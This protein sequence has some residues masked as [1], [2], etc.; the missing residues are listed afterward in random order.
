MKRARAVAALIIAVC[1]ATATAANARAFTPS[2]SVGIR[3]ID[4]VTISPDGKHVAYLLR[5]ADME[6]NRYVTD[7]MVIDVG[8][9]T[10]RSVVHDASGLAD[11]RWKPDST[12]IAYLAG[13]KQGGGESEQIDLL[14]L[15]GERRTLS[16]VPNGVDE[17]AWRPDGAAI[18]LLT[19]E[20]GSS[21]GLGFAVDDGGFPNAQ[22][23]PPERLYVL[24]VASGDAAPL[25]R[26]IKVAPSS[27]SWSGDGR[28]LAFT[29]LESTYGRESYRS[30]AM[31]IDV[32]TRTVRPLSPHRTAE[33]LVGFAP[34]TDAIAYLYQ[35]NGD[36]ASSQ[37][38]YVA[39]PTRPSA[40]SAESPDLNVI[41]ASW[42]SDGALLFAAN[43]GLTQ[44]LFVVGA[45]G[46]PR[47]LS[48][49]AFEPNIAGGFSPSVAADGSF[50]FAGG[51][52]NDPLEVVYV[53]AGLA[54]P[55][56]LTR[57]NAGVGAL[58]LGET[59]DVAWRN[60]GYVEDGIVT[61]PPHY[62]PH[63]RYPL[64]LRI[65]GGPNEASTHQFSTLN[66]TLAARGWIV[67]S[68]NYRG[69]DN[70]GE[71]YQH[72]VVN[73][74]CAGP[75]RDIVAGIERVT[76][77]FTVDRGK[78]AVSGWS[79]GGMLASWLTTRD[80]RWSA[81][82]VG[83]A[84]VDLVLQYAAGSQPWRFQFAGRTPWTGAMRV[85]REQSPIAHAAEIRT[86]TLLMV[87]LGDRLV[88][89]ADSFL[90]Y[91][92]LRDQGVRTALYAY[93]VRS[94]MPSDPQ[95]IVDYFQR[96]GDWIRSAIVDAPG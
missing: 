22:A 73:D 37:R 90:M 40:A 87:D 12:A 56:A 3:G 93:P 95:R 91:R 59:R 52:P 17:Y 8:T 75:G 84:P 76:H 33:T 1:A 46:A 39:D 55:R 45:A 34:H 50:A 10:E 80:R 74:P 15:T 29:A 69:S 19:T 30:R 23:P 68:P 18:A 70:L 51:K 62:D 6:K 27:L 9:G 77:L 78:I 81:A 26:T 25:S 72:A 65:H 96:W 42:L 66:Q 43:R 88:V 63:K 24:D 41:G 92:A 54:A 57:Q 67:F 11:P 85:Y 71:R 5:T 47:A 94:H 38:L 58:E 2:D 35:R 44:T 53:G 28:A 86:P 32:A 60:D 49:G 7:L 4:S 61:L 64:V 20:S 16:R 13:E 48:L 83:G 89:P 36:P 82:V 14:S 79:Y 31:A 21:N